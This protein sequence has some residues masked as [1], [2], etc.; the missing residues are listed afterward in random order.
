MGTP[1]KLEKALLKEAPNSGGGLLGDLADIGMSA[2]ADFAGASGMVAP[3]WAE[4]ELHFK[5]NPDKMTLAKTAKFKEQPRPTSQQ[6]DAKTPPP[7]QYVGSTNRTLS[8]AV[9]LDEWEAPGASGRDVGAMVET[10][11]K[12]MDPSSDKPQSAVPLPP[13]MSFHWGKFVF[14]GYITKA[15]A[16]FTLFRQDGSPARAEVSVVMTEHIETPGAQNPT[17]GGPAGRRSRM[18]TEGDNLQLLSY[19]EYGKSGYWRALAETNGIDD[20]LALRPGRRL[21]M[22]SREDARALR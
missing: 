1:F 3:P 4:R 18:M 11:Q 12:L 9:L 20:P 14:K 21:L 5:F 16:V 13:L 2:A 22:P 6:A 8:F 19:R 7:P 10:L 17:S 15:D